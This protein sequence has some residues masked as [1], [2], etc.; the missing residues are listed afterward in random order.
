M[1]DQLIS[2]PTTLGV[3]LA[4]LYLGAPLIVLWRSRSPCRYQLSPIL[5]ADILGN[6]PKLPEQL[7]SI[8][9]FPVAAS[10]ID[11][12]DSTT[13][14]VLFRNPADSCIANLMLPRNALTSFAIVEFT[15]VY[16]D[17][18]CLSL[19]NSPLPQIYPVWSRRRAYHIARATDLHDMY[20]RFTTLRT[21]CNCCSPITVEPGDELVLVER[22]LNEELVALEQ[23]GIYAATCHNGLRRFTIKGAYYASWKLSWPLKSIL[24]HIATK[25]ALSASDA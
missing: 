5:P 11:A 23:Q 10:Q 12:S 3:F 17:G 20:K 9:F 21:K 2:L 22:F 8:G 25:R 1:V 7:A 15:Q 19:S 14:F 18:S 6:V 16:A 4:F 24:V 13:P